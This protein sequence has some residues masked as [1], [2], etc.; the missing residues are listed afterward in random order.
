MIILSFLFLYVLFLSYVYGWGTFIA[1]K[2]ITGVLP[3]QFPLV[4]F[5]GL[6]S[7]TTLGSL[8]SIF[9]R[10]NWEFQLLLLTVGILLF[11]ILQPYKHFIGTFKKPLTKVNWI[12]ISFFVI[13]SMILIHATSLIP[14]NP[15]TSIYHAQ[16]IHWIEDY[17]AVP[18]LANLHARLGYNSSWLLL[19]AIFSFSY[20]GLGSFHFMT[21]FLFFIAAC[22]FLSG[23]S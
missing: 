18:G 10:I 5:V 6:A 19:N 9:F 15:D 16:T 22:Y 1:L 12:F 3:N 21:G 14:A 17:P 7:I 13:L 4:V 2:K 11:I 8:F 23:I 20:L